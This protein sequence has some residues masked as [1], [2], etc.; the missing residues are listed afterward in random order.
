VYNVGQALAAPTIFT[1]KNRSL[2]LCPLT[3]REWT[4]LDNAF[5]CLKFAEMP[6]IIAHAL[7]LS[8]RKHD[9]RASQRW[10]NRWCK[11]NRDALVSI[12][13]KLIEIS[14]PPEKTKVA[15]AD[16][17]DMLRQKDVSLI[18]GVF[19]EL[20]NWDATRVGALTPLQLYM[21]L[22]IVNKRTKKPGV[23]V[24]SIDQA[25]AVLAKMR[26]EGRFN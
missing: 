21:Y 18:F 9:N 24:Q 1:W 2:I 23:S 15:K 26:N 13:N 17:A 5:A 16:E 14:M 4:L 7:W 22:D 12:W 8:V 3:L 25:R 11:N 6:H 10:I 19:A 20:Y